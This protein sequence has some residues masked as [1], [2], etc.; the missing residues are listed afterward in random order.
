M[1]LSA[2]GLTGLGF[3]GSVKASESNMSFASGEGGKNDKELVE[4]SKDKTEV[5]EKRSYGNRILGGIDAM[6]GNLL[7]LDKKGG[8][9]F[10]GEEFMV[11]F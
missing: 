2:I 4:G 1:I 3:G 6:T 8:E 9:T 7:D 10:G 5:V 11:V